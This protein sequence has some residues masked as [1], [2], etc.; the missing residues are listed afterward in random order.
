[1]WVLAVAVCSCRVWRSSRRIFRGRRR[2]RRGWRRRGVVWVCCVMLRFFSFLSPILSHSPL[3]LSLPLKAGPYPPNKP[4]PDNLHRRSNLPHRLPPFTTHH[5]F[6]LG[7]PNPRLHN[8]H[9]A[10]NISPRDAHPP[11][12]RSGAE[13]ARHRRAPR[14]SLRT[15]HQRHV[16]RVHGSL[17][18]ILLRSEFRYRDERYAA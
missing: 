18:P 11:S 13:T 9:H 14:T 8:A 4:T 2:L 10:P 16:L 12:P 17:H 1:M 7:D 15:L 5:R 6:R 3:F